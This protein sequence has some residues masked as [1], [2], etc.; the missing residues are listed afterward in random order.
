[1]AL[2]EMMKPEPESVRFLSVSSIELLAAN[3]QLL[4][5]PGC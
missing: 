4:T 2:V 5:S 3:A 1:M